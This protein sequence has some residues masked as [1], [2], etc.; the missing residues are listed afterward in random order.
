MTTV[1]GAKQTLDSAP[2]IEYELQED[3]TVLKTFVRSAKTPEQRFRESEQMRLNLEAGFLPGPVVQ[4]C[5]ASL[6]WFGTWNNQPIPTDEKFAEISASAKA[7]LE[8]IDKTLD[9]RLVEV[10]PKPDIT[11]RVPPE[12][13]TKAAKPTTTPAEPAPTAAEAADMIESAPAPSTPPAKVVAPTSG[14]LHAVAEH[15]DAVFENTACRTFEVHVR[16]RRMAGD[17]TQAAEWR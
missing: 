10:L 13:A 6:F 1:N 4:D 3:E 5:A 15:G 9:S 7:D 17:H 16:S 14:I 12:A 11:Q 2:E 8:E